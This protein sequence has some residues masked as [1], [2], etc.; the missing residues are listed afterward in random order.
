MKNSYA[1]DLRVYRDIE[2]EYIPVKVITEQRC[3]RN[4][5]TLENDNVMVIPEG[6]FS[7]D[8]DLTDAEYE[9]MID[10]LCETPGIKIIGITR[11][12]DEKTATT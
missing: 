8:I 1:I 12:T 6:Y 5:L 3:R 10:W 4:T 11:I 2:A 7:F 9:Q